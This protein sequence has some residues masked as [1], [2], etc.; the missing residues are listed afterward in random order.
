MPNKFDQIKTSL[1]HLRF[2]LFESRYDDAKTNAQHNLCKRTHYVD[3]DTLKRFNCRIQS[4]HVLY[5]GLLFGIVES[6]RRPDG[7]RAY[8]GVIWDTFGT[9]IKRRK[10]DDTLFSSNKTA[11]K[12]FWLA[13][14]SLDATELTLQ[15]IR[16]HC[17]QQLQNATAALKCVDLGDNNQ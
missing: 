17:L 4:T 9:V 2:H 5:E 14:N 16:R 3:D 10:I 7:K 12:D 13:A 11:L 15:A 1:E 6:L 8:R